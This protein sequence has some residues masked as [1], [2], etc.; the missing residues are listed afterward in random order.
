MS[1]DNLIGGY[2]Y[3]NKIN[4]AEL[5][6]K[7]PEGM[8]L[9][10]TLFSKPLK[11]SGLEGVWNAYPIKTV[12]ENGEIIWFTKEGCAHNNMYSRCVIFPK[13]KFTWE[14]FIHPCTFKKGDVL[15][16]QAGN[17]V[18][19]SHIDSKNVVHY[20]CILPPGEAL[21]IEKDTS[22]GVGEYSDC[23]L[24][25]GHQKQRM[26]DKIKSAGYKYNQDTN[27]LE[28]LPKFKNG[29]ILAAGDWVCIFKELHTNGSP[30]CYCHYD[31]TLEEFKVDTN[32]YVA[33]GGDIYLATKEQQDFL[34]SK[35]EGASYKWNAETKTLEKLIKP[36]F[37]IGDQ[38]KFSCRGSI[39]V[40]T[41]IN[42]K[43][44]LLTEKGSTITFPVLI[45]SDKDWELIPKKFDINTLI[46]F[47]SKV[48]VRSMINDTWKPATFGCI[49]EKSS[50]PFVTVGGVSWVQ[51]IPYKGNEHLL[52][53][54]D[55]C[56]SY[57]KTWED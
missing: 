25:N 16:S 30:K 47:E 54:T 19:F 2:E 39:F 50:S 51:C 49:T 28:K 18:L 46:P 27:K 41:E 20:H 4:V 1:Y 17:M 15:I 21:R 8:E 38:V 22:I 3:G 6:R 34:F 57:F 42:D 56:D 5:L 26:Y 12:A 24:A 35:M 55:D 45:S 43:Y 36:R 7:C 44:Y 10:C 33:C 53:K 48:L 37:K 13:G 32:S 40:I 23:I 11:Y 9:D 14:G 31:L 29:D 52:S